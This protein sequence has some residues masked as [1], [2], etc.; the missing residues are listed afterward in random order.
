MSILIGHA[1]IDE[2]R[3]ISGGI[4]GDQTGKEVCTRAWYPKPWDFVLR[5]KDSAKA[6]KM[7][8]ACEQGCANS[9]IGYDQGQRNTLYKEAKAVNYDFSK[10]TS[11]CECDCSSFL[12]VCALAAGIPIPYGANAPT[13][14]TM[15]N[16][17]YATGEFDVL[18]DSKYLTSDAYLARG[19]IL[20]KAGSHT[21]MAL[22]NG[23]QA[24]TA[25]NAFTYTHTDFIREIQSAIGAKADGIAGPETLSKIITVSKT[26][27]YRH[28]VVKPIQKYLTS[29]GYH[30]GTVDGIAGTKFDMAVKAFQNAN[31]LTIDG[32][33]G[34]KTWRKLLWI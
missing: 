29:I 25:A 8:A 5:C 16:V 22:E 21:V 19:D 34:V 11:A 1:S 7:A 31:N 12:T 27:N 10:I 32:I 2:N 18:T 4:A 24:T 33:I 14:S 6:E 13:T 26:R 15:K 9:M 17:F 30:C 23:C 3:T 28:A 20:V